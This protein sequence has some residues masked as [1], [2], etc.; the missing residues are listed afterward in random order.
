MYWNAIWQQ[1]MESDIHYPGMT[2]M[3]IWGCMS[4][5]CKY[6]GFTIRCAGQNRGSLSDQ[7]GCKGNISYVETENLGYFVLCVDQMATYD[8]CFSAAILHEMLHLCHLALGDTEVQATFKG[9]NIDY[10]SG[11]WTWKSSVRCLHRSPFCGARFD[12]WYQGGCKPCG[13]GTTGW[14]DPCF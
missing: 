1:E 9:R 3:D 13:C 6:G 4:R 5:L 14:V 8:V 11:S 12:L 10:E 2:W 7:E